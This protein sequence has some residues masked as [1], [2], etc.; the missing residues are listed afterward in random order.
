AQMPC[1]DIGQLMA[2]RQE[3]CFLKAAHRVIWK[4]RLTADGTLSNLWSMPEKKT[5]L[6]LFLGLILFRLGAIAEAAEEGKSI[7]FIRDIQ[8]IFAERCYEC[9]GAKKQKN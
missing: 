8:P 9:H 4:I 6:G 2:V 3:G 5:C 7:D 1:L